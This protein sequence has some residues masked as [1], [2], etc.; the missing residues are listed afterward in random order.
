MVGIYC[1]ENLRDG[2]RYIGQSRNVENRLLS[3]RSRLA[4]QKHHNLLLQCAF[5]VFGDSFFLFYVI[6]E[7][8][9]YALENRER[10][11]ISTYKTNHREFGYNLT[12]G[13]NTGTRLSEESRK[14]ISEKNRTRVISDE[15]RKRMSLARVGKKNK[16]LTEEQRKRASLARI[17]KKLGH[18]KW[19]KPMSD[20]QKMKISM[21]VSG[22]RNGNHK[23]RMTPERYERVK[24]QLGA[25]RHLSNKPGLKYKHSQAFIDKQAKKPKKPPMKYKHSKQFLE[26]RAIAENRKFEKN[27][28]N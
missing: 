21:A 27:Q 4:S 6:E 19:S 8:E 12:D 9:E 18:W 2:K 10:F 16:P 20:E 3:H 14:K 1:I 25:V 22:E 26:K 28:E 5:D 23:N 24:W 17:G 11:Y 13:G 7:C 15:T